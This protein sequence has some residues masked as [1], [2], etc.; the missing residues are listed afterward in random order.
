MAALRDTIFYFPP[1]T[2]HVA[3][4]DPGVG[5]NR[6]ILLAQ[7][8]SQWVIAPD[9]GLIGGLA[10]HE[11]PRTVYSISNQ[12]LWRQPLS[13]TF[14]GRDIMKFQYKSIENTLKIPKISA[15][16]GQ[17]TSWVSGRVR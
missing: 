7:F 16:G 11:P 2:I 4:V 5:T 12:D 6:P 10:I 17:W 14:H 1:D 8:G 15:C 3:V 9:N 13:N